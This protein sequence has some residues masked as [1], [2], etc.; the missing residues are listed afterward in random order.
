MRKARAFTLV[1]VLVVVAVIALL[2]GILLPSLS[3]ARTRARAV[4]CQKY[5][6]QWG[7]CWAMYGQTHR[8]SFSDGVVDDA[9]WHRGEWVIVLRRYYDTK[10][11][12]LRCPMAM[13][14]RP[15]GKDYGGPF[16]SYFMPYGGNGSAGGG[17]E[18]SYGGNNWIYNP[19]PEK[20][21]IQGRP[22]KYNWRHMS[23]AKYP[24]RVPV[25]ADAMWRGGGPSESGSR[26]DPPVSNGQWSGYD[27]EMKHF[28]I[29]RHNGYVHHLMLD[30]SVRRV[31]LKELWK[32]KWHREFDTAG[33]WTRSGG[34]QPDWPSWMERFPEY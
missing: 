4:V 31:G 14:R 24:N 7:T 32:L 26:G 2:I 22:T 18:P 9:G 33:P 13:K 12:I 1:E 28:C 15:D 25:M 20:T 8:D 17:E 5:L 23:G 30:W 10:S 11:D 16:H 19:T 3:R 29:D 21:A 34:N 27:S 6:A